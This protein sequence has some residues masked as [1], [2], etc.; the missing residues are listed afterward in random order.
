MHARRHIHRQR[1]EHEG[2]ENQ[3]QNPCIWKLMQGKL[4]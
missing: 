4:A 2:E 1:D 3:E